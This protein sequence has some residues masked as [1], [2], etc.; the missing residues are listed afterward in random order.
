MT[1]L[2]KHTI[3]I[4]RTLQ[5]LTGFV[6][7][8][9]VSHYLSSDLQGWYFTCLSIASAYTF[10][11]LGLSVVLLQL[12]A[13]I[14]SKLKWLDKGKIIGGLSR[15]FHKLTQQS[16]S[17]FIKL[18][19]LYLIIVGP[20][21]VFFFNSYNRNNLNISVDWL[22]P[23]ITLIT[24]TSVN[25]LTIPFLALFEGSGK[26]TEVYYLRIIQNVLGS[27]FL[28]AAL[29]SGYQL[30]ALP[31]L[32]CISFLVV[33]VWLIKTKPTF[34]EALRVTEKI[35]CVD[36][37]KEV[38][39]LQWRVGLSWIAGYLLTQIYTPILFHYDSPKVAGQ[40]GLSLTI[41]NMLGL[42]AQSWIARS[43]PDMSKLVANKDW[44]N[45]DRVFKHALKLS[46]LMYL[47]GALF[48]DVLVALIYQ[49]SSYGER[50]LPIL[51]FSGL[52]VVVLINHI[53]GAFTAHLRS[54]KKEPLAFIYLITT[55]ITIPIALYEASH[56][57]ATGVVASIL[58]VQLALTLPITIFYWFK[59][60]GEWRLG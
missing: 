24:F 23:W 6:T 42:L 31:I 29:I 55:L 17:F 44:Q 34:L 60:N 45:F 33:M 47:L 56:F 58:L 19:S 16:V 41:A 37:K 22:L 38:W 59:F 13:H 39:P 12:S 40:M 50:I 26:V 27:L 30:W 25:M 35:K 15:K 52:L 32:P 5:A 21:G 8:L 7:I 43:V 2:L 53:N 51:P 10:F 14:F 49:F 1:R 20:L 36:W 54:Y 28:W 48:L 46:V 3:F 11:D 57:S 4:Q 18:A 9:V